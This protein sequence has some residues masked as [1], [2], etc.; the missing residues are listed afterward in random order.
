MSLQKIAHGRTY[1]TVV[2]LHRELAKDTLLDILQQT[3]L[4]KGD[5]IEL[6]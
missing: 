1:K 6:L 5:L 4:E 2:L 3:G